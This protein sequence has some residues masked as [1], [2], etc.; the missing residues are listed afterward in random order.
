MKRLRLLPLDL[1]A[2][3]LETAE[4]SSLAPTIL[5]LAAE[6]E[7][8]L[9]RELP[10]PRQ[11]ARLT[12]AGGRCPVHGVLLEFDPWSPQVHRC[13]RCARAYTSVEHDDWWAMGAQ[14]YTAE[15]AVHAA[16]LY[17]LRGDPTHAALAV[18][19]LSEFADRYRQWP[20]RDNVLGPA[21]PFFSTYLESIWLL[22]LCHA[23]DLLDASMAPGADHMGAR[24]RGQ[25]IAPSAAL[26]ASYHEGTSN[27]QVWNEVAVLSAYRVLDDQH[28]FQRRLDADQGLLSLLEQGLLTDGTWYEGENYHLFAHRGLWYGVQLLAAAGLSLPA[29][30]SDRFA[31]GFVT[32]FLGLLPDEIIPARRDSQY[33][34]SIRQW[35]FAEWCELGL[36]HRAHPRLAGLLSRLYDG[37]LTHHSHARARST[38]DAERN[39]APSALSRADLSWRSLLMASA[40]PVPAASWAP[41][42]VLLA[43]QGLAVLRREHGHVYVALEGGHSGSGHGHPDRLALTLQTGP[44]RWLQDPGTGSYVERT[45]HWYRSTL[46]HHAPLVNGGSQPPATATLV[47]FEDRGGMGWVQKRASIGQGIRAT[48]TLVV[49]EGYAIDLLEWSR[50]PSVAASVTSESDEITITLPICGDALRT[51]PSDFAPTLRPGAGALEDGF[52]FLHHVESVPIDGTVVID[53]LAVTA[54]SAP[55][56]RANAQLV[57]AAN[58]PATLLR[59]RAPG[60]PGCSETVRHAV[61]LHGRT[62]RLVS[63]WHWQPSEELPGVQR[64]LLDAFGGAT[65]SSEAPVAR[66]TTAD[67]TT[68]VHGP[69]AHGWHIELLARHAR[70]S[71]DLEGLVAVVDAD[72]I[73]EVVATALPL[74]LPLQITLGE[75]HYLRTEQSWR[76]AD[77]P[78]ATVHVAVV[79]GRVVVEVVATTGVVVPADGLDNSLDNERAEVN[80]DGVQWYWGATDGRWRQAALCT[81]SDSAVLMTRLVPGDWPLPEAAWEALA[82]DRGWRVRFEWKLAD[83]PLASD[84]TVTFDLVVNERPVNR[85]RRRGQLLL[86]GP[87]A[88]YPSAGAYAYLRGDRHSTAHAVRLR[89]GPQRPGH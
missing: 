71:V 53:A 26:I 52:D 15:R 19:I 14:L 69:A 75:A 81:P 30:L 24:L 36:A 55:V 87:P 64:V 23:L 22:N 20:N 8:L 51:T 42:S 85:M 39:E 27:R 57:L 33:A 32:P 45:L 41:D 34:V 68:A 83:L 40:R 78:T 79:G 6:L 12:R 50:D 16:T 84:G 44:E 28:A 2:R 38:A 66:I 17:A 11:K 5:G 29:A 43:S 13:Q 61:E 70:S 9:L 82:E 1:D 35:R 80:A 59:A 56:H 10:I 77:R 21:R 18:R 65:P 49:C 7:P 37:S 73:S 62:G 48:R 4:G 72:H 31:A 74:S 89:L 47:A 46:A 67:G 3:R 76:E 63:V 54:D 60:A 25:L 88:A 86:S 58:V